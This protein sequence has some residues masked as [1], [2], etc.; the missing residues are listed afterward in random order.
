MAAASSVLAVVLGHNRSKAR[1]LQVVL[2]HEEAVEHMETPGAVW[3]P[4]PHLLGLPLVMVPLGEALHLPN[5]AAT[6]LLAAPATGTPPHS[7]GGSVLV[8]RADGGDFPLREYQRWWAF[9][10]GTLVPLY[11]V[12]S[13]D[14]D[15]AAVLD[16]C[17]PACLSFVAGLEDGN[18]R[19]PG[20][21][22]TLRAW[23]HIWRHLGAATR[24]IKHLL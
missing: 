17:A 18:I 16:R 9:L 7:V 2:S 4:L 24:G 19:R 11:V 13:D 20:L 14:R 22:L 15:R 1:M 3:C 8:L 10:S 21:A 6:Y 5:K 12:R 23:G